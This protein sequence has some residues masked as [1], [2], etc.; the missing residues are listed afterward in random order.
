ME[1]NSSIL[2]ST[3]Q[4]IVEYINTNLEI[5]KLKVLD[6][7][8]NI[9]A[10][11]VSHSIFIFL[12]TICILFLNIG[13]ALWLGGILGQVFFGFLIVAAFNGII[14]LI[15]HIFMHEKIKRVIGNYI[16]KHILN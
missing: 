15:L 6:K 7:S 9:V 2:E 4:K 10:S 3:L 5:I 13:L 12:I 14:A 1:N 8:S 11:C 16:I